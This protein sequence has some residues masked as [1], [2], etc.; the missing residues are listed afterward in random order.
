LRKG[1]IFSK[2]LGIVLLSLIIGMVTNQGFVV[3]AAKFS[4]GDIVEVVNTL[5]VGL[6]VRDAPAGNIIG[7]K[8]DGDRGMILEGPQSASLGGVVYTWWKVR[9]GDDALE[10][11]SAEGYPGGVDY[12]KKVYVSPSTKFSI[13]D[14]VKVYNTGIYG[15]VVRTDPPALSYKDNEVDGTF[16]KVEGGPF[17]GVAEGK[18]GFYH[19][20]KVNYGSV[21]GWSAEDWLMKA[22]P[23]DLTVEDIWIEPASFNPG[24]T[25]TIY[26]R[27]K[28]I[29][30]SAAISDQGLQIR[31]YFDGSLCYHFSMLSLLNGTTYT[32]QCTYAWPSD[33]GMHTIKVVVD[34][35]NYIVESN[36]N[37]NELSKPFG[38]S[39]PTENS[40]P[41]LSDGYVTPSSGDTSTIFYYYVTY[42]DPDDDMPT[43]SYV[44]ID[45]SPCMMTALKVCSV[46]FYYSTTLSE[47]SHN[48]YFYFDDGHGHAVRLPSSG[49]YSGPVVSLP[50]ENRPPNPPTNL[51][52][53]KDGSPI[54]VGAVIDPV[55]IGPIFAFEGEVSDPD[56]DRVKLQVELR[57]LDEYGGFFNETAGGFKESELVESGNIA[58]AYAYGLIAGSYHWR[59]RT[60]DEHGLTSNW[61]DFG[62]NLIS[63]ADFKLSMYVG[64]PVITSPL[65][66]LSSSPHP[67]GIGDTLMADFTITNK[68]E[69]PITLDILVVG[70]RSPSG[71]VVDF[72]KVYDLTLNP[73]D[74][75][76]YR[77]FLTLPDE[78]GMYYFFC[79]YYIE[80]PTEEESKF[81]DEN[82]WNTNI[83]VEID[84]KMLT[85]DEAKFY[86]EAL[87]MVLQKADSY[88][89]P[90]KLWERIHGPWESITSDLKYEIVQVVAHPRDPQTFYVA[91]NYKKP[92]FEYRLQ[93][94]YDYLSG[95][96]YKFSHGSW[97]KV[98]EGLSLKKITAIAI[99]R[100]NPDIIYAGSDTGLYK[101]EDG[102]KTWKSLNGPKVGLWVFKRYA[103]ISSIAVD[104]IN[105]NIVYMCTDEGIW[106]YDGN[107]WK[108]ITKTYSVAYPIKTNPF[109]ANTI[110][111]SGFDVVPEIKHV[112]PAGF[113][114]SGDGGTSWRSKFAKGIVTDVTVG[115]GETVYVSTGSY[116]THFPLIG[117]T[118]VALVPIP[119]LV[120]AIFRY[121]G[122][123]E[124]NWEDP[125]FWRDATGKDSINPLPIGLYSS[126]AVNPLFPNQVFVVVMNKGVYY[127]P[128]SGRDWFYLGLNEYIT[129]IVFA[130]D[131]ELPIVYAYGPDAIFKLRFSNKV[132][133][134][135]RYSTSELRVYDMWGNV[136]GLINGERREEI[137]RSFYDD[138]SGTVIIF[139]LL[140]LYYE[141]VGVKNETYGLGIIYANGSIINDFTV[142]NVPITTGS[143]HQFTINWSTLARGEEGVTVRVDSDADGV[144]ELTFT[145][146]SELTQSEYVGAMNAIKTWMTDSDFNDIE[147]FRAVFTPY[148]NTELYK[149]TATNPGQLYLNILVNNTWPEPLNL[150][151]VYSIN[152]DFTFKGAKPIH[153]YA[154]L[155][156]T[157]DITADCTFSDNTI[158]VYNV[159]PNAIIYV[160][161][162]LDYALKG[163]TWTAE[164]VEAWYSEH[165]FSATVR[166]VTSKVVIT[167]PELKIPAT[168]LSLIFLTDALPATILCLGIVTAL[169]KYVL[170]S[171]KR[172]NKSQNP[173]P[174]FF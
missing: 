77:G 166:S 49:V 119:V 65:R 159:A 99:A 110:Y 61:V 147:S 80:N 50:P 87:V 126:L 58:T 27:I 12:L 149:L 30:G 115:L 124:E 158:T 63:E 74:S 64:R 161:I 144:F 152:A 131:K 24:S 22:T 160:T 57:R 43:I 134:A 93:P 89:T 33:T 122:Y 163:T 85:D 13:G 71:K 92:L 157:I 2:I 116:L 128:S 100:T 76:D 111:A 25:V 51:A 142:I 91:V 48:Y 84:G 148:R 98:S 156:R 96:I 1:K 45:G 14:F 9:W 167:D 108:K 29:G 60:V 132:I 135:R 16:G 67:F 78:A 52:Q 101:S 55:Y 39:P 8:Y 94:F 109:E 15:L 37:N 139:P 86:R 165:G 28:N 123:G 169:L 129:K 117:K 172:Q 75:H 151:I 154:D 133:V 121:D 143:V 34:P 174:L 140:P 66:I 6:R 32:F 164:E 82:N 4:S 162:H 41:T 35:F 118:E 47:G 5:D 23:S 104:S 11:W 113:L 38:P 26:S 46:K 59:A 95:D 83:D 10:G 125:E 31:A 56:G 153:V 36:E 44:Y 90:A 73:G 20:W 18:A 146:D 88:P 120:D 3:F 7:K 62:N 105:P 79:A 173:N 70:G 130:E 150:T 170:L 103:A 136:T 72:D 81:L 69:V 137:L 17:Y 42:T 40:P 21:V 19:F 168:P 102:G 171:T 106:K 141:I 54:E 97:E 114:R 127:S 53:F 138:E 107:Y 145:S 155:E 112:S 68:G